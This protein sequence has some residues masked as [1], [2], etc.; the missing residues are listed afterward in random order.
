MFKQ[1]FFLS[2]HPLTLLFSIIKTTFNN[3]YEHTFS[4]ISENFHPIVVKQGP[5]QVWFR[6]K[7][8]LIFPCALKLS[9]YFC[10]HPY[11]FYSLPKYCQIWRQV[12]LLSFAGFLFYSLDKVVNL[13]LSPSVSTLQVA[14]GSNN[15]SAF[16]LCI[17][18]SKQSEC[19]M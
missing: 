6:E 1:R 16:M 13:S 14:L 18:C 10:V 15:L 4:Y 9:I 3:K 8:L 2:F 12:V 11:Q 7:F 17:L 5:I 19:F